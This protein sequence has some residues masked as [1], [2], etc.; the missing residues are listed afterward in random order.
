MRNTKGLSQQRAREN[1]AERENQIG[2][3]KKGEKFVES[4]AVDKGGQWKEEGNSA[5]ECRGE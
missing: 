3:S 4:V 5:E 1:S 2:W